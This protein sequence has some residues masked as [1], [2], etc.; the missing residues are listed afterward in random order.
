M[1]ELSIR[2]KESSLPTGETAV[3]AFLERKDSPS[4][5]P[6]GAE[7]Y[8]AWVM[9]KHFRQAMTDMADVVR[10]MEP[11]SNPK[12]LFNPQ[13]KLS[14]EDLLRQHKA[15]TSKAPTGETDPETGSSGQATGDSLAT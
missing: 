7:E 5:P 8:L 3:E 1:I 6:T 4:S 11:S 2:I 15:S 9:N 12:I 13:P 10:E 14:A